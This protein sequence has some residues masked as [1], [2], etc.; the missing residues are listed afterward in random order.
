MPP[1]EMFKLPAKKKTSVARKQ[2]PKEEEEQPQIQIKL[3]KSSIVKRTWE[4]DKLQT[5]DL[6]HHEFEEVPLEEE[7]E[8]LSSVILSQPIKDKE[9]NLEVDEKKK[10]KK[11]KVKQK[12]S[13]NKS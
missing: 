6:T 9:V 2:L 1:E 5:V 7:P 4:D 10:K 12:I 13:V 11:K 8:L 3:R